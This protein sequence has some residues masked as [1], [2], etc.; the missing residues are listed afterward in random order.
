MTDPMQMLLQLRGRSELFPANSRYHGIET[1]QMET[2]EGRTILYMRRRFIP[3]PERLAL[4]QEHTVT[5]G[6]RLDNISA[7]YLGDPE[8]FWRL[9]DANS[10]MRPGELTETIGRRLRITLPD[11]IPGSANG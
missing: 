5:Q 1:A 11:G 9:C 4:L 10:A 3:D 2:P 6:D 8:M 7:H